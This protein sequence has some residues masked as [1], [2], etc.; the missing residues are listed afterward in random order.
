MRGAVA[1]N[2]AYTH[3]GPATA[4]GYVVSEQVGAS[5]VT[6]GVL[7]CCVDRR[8]RKRL[9]GMPTLGTLPKLGRKQLHQCSH[10]TSRGA[11]AEVSVQSAVIGTIVAHVRLILTPAPRGL[12]ICWHDCP[13]GGGSGAQ[14]RILLRAVPPT[15]DA[16]TRF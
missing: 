4:R 3:R 14:G 12:P 2:A 8:G 7:P 10:R 11:A 16:G 5:F 9:A 15:R 1:P 6:N 13:G